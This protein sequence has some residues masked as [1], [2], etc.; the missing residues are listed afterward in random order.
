MN[1]FRILMGM[2]IAMLI[3]LLSIW[4]YK[5]FHQKELYVA[6]DI[7][8]IQQCESGIIS[9]HIFNPD[10]KA[11]HVGYSVYAD[12]N[13]NAMLDLTDQ[14][15]YSEPKRT[16]GPQAEDQGIGIGSKYK[17]YSHIV[18]ATTDDVIAYY[19]SIPCDVN[20]AERDSTPTK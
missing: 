2:A 10:T 1:N 20:M 17:G 3:S 4:F 14:F 11:M 7:E 18:K 12:L 9:V 6:P 5:M 19:A 15:I 16:L 13:D 8:F